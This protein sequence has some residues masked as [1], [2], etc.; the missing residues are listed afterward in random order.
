MKVQASSAVGQG[1]MGVIFTPAVEE[2]GQDF[3]QVWEPV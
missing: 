2:M 1:E 3:L